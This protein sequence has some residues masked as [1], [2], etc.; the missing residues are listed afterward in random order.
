[1]S[2]RR[3]VLA[4]VLFVP[5]ALLGGFILLV[6]SPWGAQWLGA[7]VG[8]QIHREVQI[9]GI[10]VKFE[11]PPALTF[12]RLRIGNPPWAKTP[13]LLDA[14]G[15]YARVSPAPLFEKRIVIPYLAAR[16]ANA[17]LELDGAR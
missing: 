8:S 1:M 7:R 14:R 5:L 16:S 15:L 4:L 2:V 3:S 13:S 9:E 10:R 17:G 12:Q 6:Q 11:W